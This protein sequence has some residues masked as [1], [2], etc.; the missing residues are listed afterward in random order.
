MLIQVIKVG[1][2]LLSKENYLKEL[3]DYIET[4]SKK[5]KVI[6]VCSAIGRGHD[7]YST[8]GLYNSVTGYLT[9][10][11]R[12]ELKAIGETYSVL[13]VAGELRRFNLRVK[14]MMWHEIGLVIEGKNFSFNA[15]PMKK[16]LDQCDVLV[17]PG[18]IGMD[19][20]G[21]ATTFKREGSDYSAVIF[22]Y[23]LGQNKCYLVKDIIGVYD[24][25]GNIYHELTY[26]DFLNITEEFTSP[27]AIDAIK[28]CMKHKMRLYIINCNGCIACKIGIKL[29]F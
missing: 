8:D 12:G 27:V 6:L 14:T 15:K 20:S 11:E 10:V 5:N 23:Y 21:R 19:A 22:S 28:F 1:G 16:M 18:F 2:L 4:V 7:P 17:V 26:K 24:K 13:K 25:E 9:M 3:F 29:S